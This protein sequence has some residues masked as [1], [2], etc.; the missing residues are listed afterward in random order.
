[1]ERNSSRV[2]HL[3]NA[4]RNQGD[5]RRSSRLRSSSCVLC[6]S[7]IGVAFVVKLACLE[8][9]RSTTKVDKKPEPEPVALVTR[10]DPRKKVKLDKPK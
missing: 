3:Y 9:K 6:S 7:S 8:K 2:T 4:G 10:S 5:Y 1:M